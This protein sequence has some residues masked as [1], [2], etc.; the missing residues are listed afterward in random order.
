MS[1]EGE[2]G[3]EKK[4]RRMKRK[5]EEWRGRESAKSLEKD[6]DRIRT[7]GL[8]DSRRQT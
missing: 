1:K 4:E 2:E 7:S 5:R 3:R 8:R 6:P